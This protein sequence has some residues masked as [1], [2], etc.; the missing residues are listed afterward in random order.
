[1]KN[2]RNYLR[3]FKKLI[4]DYSLNFYPEAYPNEAGEMEIKETVTFIDFS[5]EIRSIIPNVKLEIENNFYD[6]NTVWSNYFSREKLS[7]EKII[8]KNKNKKNIDKIKNWL[9]K[10]EIE[11]ENL[12]FTSERPYIPPQLNLD[13]DLSANQNEYD[14]PIWEY[15][16]M[17][18]DF[19][20]F[21]K[22]KF[23]EFIIAYM[24]ELNQIGQSKDL[25]IDLS[26]SKG[27]EKIILLEKLGVLNFL[28]EQVPFNMSK[29]ALASV[30]SGFTGMKLE[31]VQ[32]YINPINNPG[33]NQKNNPLSKPKTVKKV[34]EKLNNIG[35][36]TPK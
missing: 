11:V 34:I 17:Q 29:N 2:N 22:V 35:Y 15:S 13:L 10:Y 6:N 26:N 30:I 20:E 19:L 5:R 9:N 4:N 7:L 36:N 28:K 3:T 33:V 1:M 21:A 8:E 16:D 18:D 32:S 31:T 25:P 12:D 23:V 14:D 24:E 27:N